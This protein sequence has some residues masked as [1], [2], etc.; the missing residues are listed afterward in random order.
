ML[1]QLGSTASPVS[2]TPPLARSPVP[3]DTAPRRTRPGAIE[4]RQL[5]RVVAAAALLGVLGFTGKNPWDRTRAARLAAGTWRYQ[6][7]DVTATNI[8]TAQLQ[9]VRSWV[10]APTTGP[11]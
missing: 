5:V 2:L 10:D 11:P 9:G 7:E 4:I 8:P 3:A 6:Y 1:I